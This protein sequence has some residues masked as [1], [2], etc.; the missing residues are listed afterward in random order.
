MIS[1]WPIR[2]GRIGA[3]TENTDQPIENLY[4]VNG[5]RRLHFPA[6]S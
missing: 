3:D 4:L 1:L 5:G 2:E 6:S